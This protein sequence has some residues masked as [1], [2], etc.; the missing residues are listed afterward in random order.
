LGPR[1][2]VLHLTHMLHWT[3]RV[4]PVERLCRLARQEGVL[5]VVDG[6]QTFAQ[7]PVSFRALG[8]DY[9]ATSLHKWLGAP[10]GNGMLLVK[11]N[12]I[13]E[14]FPL[15]G[16]FEWPPTGIDKFDHWNLGTYNSALQA[17]ILPA[18][19]FHQSIGTERVHARRG[20]LTRQWIELARGIPGF[21]LHTPTV[22]ED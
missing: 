6:A 18:V 21:R 14:T 5:T 17:G 3:G 12:R 8:C 1:V 2:R 20:Q 9:F 22:G 19:R 16:P 7:T 15:L 10:V 4:L 13:E 11:Q